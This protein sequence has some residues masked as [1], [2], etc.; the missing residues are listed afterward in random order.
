VQPP[1][2]STI[3]VPGVASQGD[4]TRSTITA[5]RRN[6]YD[7]RDQPYLL[8]QILAQSGQRSKAAGHRYLAERFHGPW[9]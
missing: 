8:Y 5:S 9:Q 4:D 3:V 2:L 7:E 1:A 6:A